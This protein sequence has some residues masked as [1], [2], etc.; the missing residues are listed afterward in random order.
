[1]RRP[2]EHSKKYTHESVVGRDGSILVNPGLL[3]H[4]PILAVVRKKTRFPEAN[5]FESAF[6]RD[7]GVFFGLF[8]AHSV[9]RCG[10]DVRKIPTDHL[11][12][13]MHQIGRTVTFAFVFLGIVV[14]QTSGQFAAFFHRHGFGGHCKVLDVTEVVSHGYDERRVVILEQLVSRLVD[15]IDSLG[16]RDS[17]ELFR[18]A[19]NI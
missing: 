10:C 18:W 4:R 11:E 17:N 9:H 2:A 5:V 12:C 6:R 8:P 1:M 19:N 3:D 7:L 14:D 16:G 15:G 13:R